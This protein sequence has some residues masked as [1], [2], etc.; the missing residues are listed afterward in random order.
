MKLNFV[1]LVFLLEEIRK[2][3]VIP[4]ILNKKKRKLTKWLFKLKSTRY[5]E[6]LLRY[7]STWNR[8]GRLLKLNR[9][10]KNVK[11]LSFFSTT[12]NQK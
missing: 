12:F 5:S 11:K 7:V 9:E 10:F 8:F 1:L 4:S 3:K 2:T 6:L